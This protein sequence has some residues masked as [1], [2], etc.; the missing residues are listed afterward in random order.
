MRSGFITNIDKCIGCNACEIACKAYKQLEPNMKYRKVKELDEN[1]VGSPMRVHLSYACNHCEKPGCMEVCPV[2]AFTK[3]ED[4]IVILDSEICIG[5]KACLDGCPYQAPT[6]N[7]EEE[8]M[9]KCDYC[10]NRPEGHSTRCVEACPMG[11]LS[12]VNMEEINENDFVKNVDGF[13]DQSITDA[14]L[15]MVMPKEVTQYRLK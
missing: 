5:C 14:N 15:R 1:L 9:H 2:G 11:A 7:I 6:F 12:N 13:V 4:G 3:N 8:K 10:V